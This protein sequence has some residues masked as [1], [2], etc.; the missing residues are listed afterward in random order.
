M[1]EHPELPEELGKASINM[2]KFGHVLPATVSSL[3]HKD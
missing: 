3:P 1:Q 2:W